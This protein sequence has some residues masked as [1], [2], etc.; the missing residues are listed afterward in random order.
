MAKKTRTNVVKLS[1]APPVPRWY[2]GRVAHAFFRNKVA[3]VGLIIIFLIVFAALTAPYISPYDP[4]EIHAADR[5]AP[6]GTT[7]FLGTDEFGRDIFSRL[8]YGAS[9]SIQ[10]ALI[11]Q[12]I[13]ISIGVVVGLV[14][15]WYGGWIDD[16]IMRITDAIF[17]LPGLIFLI[18]WVQII[19]E[20]QLTFFTALGI[21]A[22]KASI[23]LALGLIG[24]AGTAR[25]MR[26]QVLS[27]K[28]QEFVLSAR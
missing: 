21:D 10:I 26:S 5:L 7:Y 19:D 17:A 4:N 8:L 25:M 22:K 1:D 3:I 24:W 14:S 6:P 28:E 18:V 20:D 12:S 9:I 11:A 16:L 27:L 13:S 23:F 15:G 2:Q